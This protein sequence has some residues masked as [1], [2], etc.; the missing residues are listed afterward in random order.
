MSA[1]SLPVSSSSRPLAVR[2]R[3]DLLVNIQL[4]QGREYYVVKDPLALRFFRFEAEEYAL[5][6]ML[7]GR[8][9]VDDIRVEFASR[10]APQKISNGEL[11]QFVGSLHRGCLLVSNAVGQATTL[12]ER[13]D[14]DKRRQRRAALTNVLAIR[15]RGFDPDRLLVILDACIGWLFSLPAVMAS[16]LMMM[17]ALGQVFTNFELFQ[18]K[19]PSFESFFAGKNWIWLG[20]VLAGTKLWHELG[21]GVC[22]KRMGSQCHSM[23]I[24]FLVLMPCLYCD[25]SDSWTLVSKWRR[26]AIA[27]AGM[28]FE[29]I[30]ASVCVFVWWFSEP[31]MINMLALNVVV[32]SS[33]STIM[34]N[35]NPLMR[36]DGYYILCDMVEVPNLRQKAAS[37][38]SRAASFWCLGI[39]AGTDPFMPVRHRALF[40]LYSVA[41]VAYRWLITLSIFWFLY[42]LLEPYGLKLVGQGIALMALYGL[43]VQPLIQFSRFLKTP[44]RMQAV[45]PARAGLTGIAIAV[46]LIA[47]LAIPVPHY[48]NCSFL[49]QPEQASTVYV[50]VPGSLRSIGVQPG[51]SVIAGQPLVLLGNVDLINGI[52]AL[53][54]Q[55]VIAETRHRVKLKQASFNQQAEGEIEMTLASL[56][57]TTIQLEQQRYDIQKL[58][59]RAPC[60][61]RVVSASYIAPQHDEQTGRLA[62]WHGH[63]LEIRNRGAWLESGAVVCSIAPNDAVVEATLAIDQSDIEFIS[64]GNTVELWLRQSPGELLKSEIDV[65]SIVEMKFVPRGLSSRFG[66]DLQTTSDEEGR[67][68][69]SSTT[70]QVRVPLSNID[71]IVANGATGKARIRTGNQTAGQRIWRAIC[72]TFRFD[73]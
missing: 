53:E 65:I 70:Y 38:L 2:K 27:A 46:M 5:L 37:V 4:W 7:D 28:Y 6:Q 24:M 67:D 11:I 55:Q 39:K 47:I 49:V 13:A 31:G 25:V 45:K 29:F 40:G 50:E 10:F 60:D 64:T 15:F 52:V 14:V 36:Y 20:I 42:R 12:L 22:C 62:G 69:P 58:T 19:L 23:G 48:V 43:L 41:A 9:S 18:Q 63:P 33:I 66:G 54:S 51:Q 59:V 8:R 21:H 44:G 35:A 17:F 73:L 71:A 16:L 34:F 32:V 61:G 72:N 26:A 3:A 68:V 57:A 1:G 56:N 30:L